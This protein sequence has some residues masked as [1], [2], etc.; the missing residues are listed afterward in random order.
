[1]L[2]WSKASLAL[3]LTGALFTASALRGAS[4]AVVLASLAVAVAVPIAV[5]LVMHPLLGTPRGARTPISRP[6]LALFAALSLAGS[7]LTMLSAPRGPAW[8]PPVVAFGLSTGVFVATYLLWFAPLRH[9]A[10][11]RALAD[12][13]E[14]LQPAV[15]ALVASFDG[16][17]PQGSVPARRLALRALTAVSA[18]MDVLAFDAAAA[19]IAR[20]DPSPLKGDMRAAVF[21][22]KASVALQRAEL[23]V[24]F[25]HLKEAAQSAQS[26]LMLEVL[27]LND[28]LLDAL[29]GRG[30]EALAKLERAT[31]PREPLRR[32]ALLATRAHALAASGDESAAKLAVD[33]MLTHAE[34]AERVRV[35]KRSALVLGPAKPLFE[36]KL[37][38]LTQTGSYTER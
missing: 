35:L 30:R 25:A 21:A 18:L 28:A 26:P 4:A 10:A 19:V 9:I 6:W 17:P 13:P 11:V 12:D 27:L 5:D 23:N 1:M 37:R 16:P 29:E 38:E 22:T 14:R 3:L 8:M 7:A 34:P 2:N 20:V 24:A 31:P 33:E 15:A 32:R 36:A